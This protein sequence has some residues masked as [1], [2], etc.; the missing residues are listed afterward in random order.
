MA[1]AAEIVD[2]GA[3]AGVGGIVAATACPGARIVLTDINPRALRLARVNALAAGV[4]VE[5]VETNGLA[6]VDDPIDVVIAN[7]PYMMDAQRRAYRDG[8][9]MRGSRLSL[10]LAREAMH[11]LAPGGRMLLY[12]GSAIVDGRDQL[13]AALEMAT[14]EAGCRLAYRELDVD[15]FGEELDRVEYADVDRIAA[16]GAIISKPC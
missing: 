16:I 12:T 1:S 10:D 13:R 7:P 14:G 2:I 8:G 6:R 11:R 3:G 5:L 4:D 9:E 15:V